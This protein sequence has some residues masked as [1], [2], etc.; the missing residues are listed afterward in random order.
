MGFDGSGEWK[1]VKRKNY[2]AGRRWESRGLDDRMG[3]KRRFNGVHADVSRVPVS[4]FVTNLPKNIQPGELWKRC[5][6]IGSVV[7]VFIS[8]KLS[9]M[10]RRF[11]F[12]RFIRVTV[13]K[14]VEKKL[15]EIWIESYHL[16][17]ALAISRNNNNQVSSSNYHSPPRYLTL[18][19]MEDSIDKKELTGLR[20]VDSTVLAEVRDA[21]TIPNLLNLCREE[22]FSGL[23]IRHVGGL[24]VWVACDSSNVCHALMQN[25]D[26]YFDGDVSSAMDGGQ[27]E[28]SSGPSKPPGWSHGQPNGSRISGNSLKNI[29]RSWS[30]RSVEMLRQKVPDTETGGKEELAKYIELGTML[31]YNVEKAKKR[32]TGGAYK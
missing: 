15:Y 24:W 17:A 19:S 29:R 1:F 11:G 5:A 18:G 22:G 3:N 4:F 6:K 13:K 20:E 12:V 31:G 14:E 30:E 32:V 10:G 7:D 23:R 9:K 8:P 21:T 16:F 27:R 25:A 2:G 28:A 26:E